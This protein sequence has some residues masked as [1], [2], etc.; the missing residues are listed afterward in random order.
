MSTFSTAG[1]T[2]NSHPLGLAAALATI[3]VY[4]EDGLIEHSAKMGEVMARHHQELADKHPSAAGPARH[5][6]RG[7]RPPTKNAAA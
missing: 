6:G 5:E 3:R 1:L 4:E 2:Y 7:A